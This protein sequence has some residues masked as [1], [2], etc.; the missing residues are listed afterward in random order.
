MCLL[1]VCEVHVQVVDAAQNKIGQEHWLC[2]QLKPDASRSYR[3]D[4]R[5]KTGREV[6]VGFC[7]ELMLHAPCMGR[8]PSQGCL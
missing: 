2:M 6:K 7:T 3:I 1:Q 4:N 8:Q 5:N